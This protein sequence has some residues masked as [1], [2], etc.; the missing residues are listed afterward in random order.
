MIRR[1]VV[2]ACE[3]I[4]PQ[5]IVGQRV[6]VAKR[7]KRVVDHDVIGSDVAV[8]RQR[9]IEGVEVARADIEQYVEQPAADLFDFVRIAR[10]LVQG[11]RSC[12]PEG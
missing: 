7:R 5:R 8:D 11:E 6:G 2:H 9:A 3:H 1:V 10:Q 12:A 4:A